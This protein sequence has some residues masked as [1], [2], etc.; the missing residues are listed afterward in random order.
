MSSE[1]Y[2]DAFREIKE[3]IGETAKGFEQF[4]AGQSKK[5]D[6][7]DRDIDDVVDRVEELESKKNSIGKTSGETKES[8]MHA[9]LFE[10]WMRH[11]F[12]GSKRQALGDF[13]SKTVTLGSGA[14]GEYAVPEEIARDIERFERKLSPVRD[15]VKVMKSSTGDFKHLLD[16]GGATAGWVTE[17]GSRTESSTPTLREIVPTGGEIYAYPQVSEWA[18][19]DIF[20]N[21]Q[22]WLVDSVSEKFAEIEGLAVI[23]GSGSGQ[24]TG[25]LNTTP[26]T[27][28]DDAVSPRAAAAYQYILGSDN[29]PAAVDAD[30]LIDLVYSVNAKYRAG[31]TF[32]MNSTTAGSV[33]K[34]KDSGTGSFVWQPGLALGQ[35]DRLLGYP[36]SVWEQM[37][38]VAGGAFPVAFGNFQ[39]GYLLVDRTQLRVTVDANLTT[40]G[41]I[42]F[43]VRRRESGAPL[44]NDAV[45]FL[46]CL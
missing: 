16:L 37:P 36:V 41:R 14:A 23:S 46:R 35:P 1:R 2:T 43:F 38:D 32:V 22:N 13:Q 19:D 40:P 6:E 10:D 11:P 12:D 7:L 4:K 25:M 26:V 18:L 45:K 34:L 28:A 39:R 3:A 42:K 33:R 29:S 20:F 44:N 30:A 5:L 21:V 27:T 17:T 15:L 24:L 9:T 8:R 31:A